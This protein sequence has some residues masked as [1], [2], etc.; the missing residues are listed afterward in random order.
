M[1]FDEAFN[2]VVGIEGGYVNDPKDSGG[3]TRYGIT[4]RVARAYGYQGQMEMMPLS[5]A[6]SIYRER[7]WDKLLL[8][9]VAAVA[10]G[11]VADELFDTAVNQGTAA[12]ATY[13]QRALNALNQEAALYADIPVDGDLGRLTVE[14]LRSYMRR[15][16]NEGATV[17]L[18]ALNALQGEFY[19]RLAEGKKTQERFVYGWLLNRVQFA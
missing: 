4:E 14:S 8:E 11:R 15:R 10:G 2:R 9:N 18:R 17:L 19:I 1:S 16:G 6:K 13:L 7:Y 5:I 3:A 12:A